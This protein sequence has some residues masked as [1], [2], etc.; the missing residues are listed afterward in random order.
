MKL[1]A[2]LIAGFA[3]TVVLS[4]FMIAKGMMGVMPQLN[5]I[6]D[7]VRVTQGL[8]GLNLPPPFGWVGHFVLGTVLWGFLYAALQARV[9]GTPVVKGLIFGVAAWLVMMIVFMPLAGHGMFAMS[10]GPQAAMATLVLHLIFGAVL[11]LVYAKVA[12][13]SG[14]GGG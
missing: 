1:K 9:P 6:E 13:G 8:T 2:G 11:G 5:P 12:R 14:A 3:A 4:M 7:I 10:L